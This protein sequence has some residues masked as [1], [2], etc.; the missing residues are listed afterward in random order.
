MFLDDGVYQL[1]KG[2]Q[3]KGIEMKNFSP[4]YRALEGYD[5]EKL[6]VERESLEARGLTEDDLLRDGRG[7][8]RAR[9]MGE[10]MDEQDVVLS[11]LSRREAMLHIV[12]KSPARARCARRAACASRAPGGAAADRGRRLRRHPRQRR[13]G[14]AARG[15]RAGCK[16]YV[17][18]PDLEARG[19][20]D[21]VHRRRDD[22]RLRRLR[23]PR[24]RAQELPILAVTRSAIPST[25]EENRM[26]SI[27]VNGKTYETDEEGYLVNLAD[28]NED[29]ANA[30]RARPR[31]SR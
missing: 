6:Y 20:A 1:K 3:T 17:L 18:L 10:L 11:L 26:A 28:W 16:V 22:R 25:L 14:Q 4:T 30:H 27:E 7:A 21:R 23:R 15:A 19:V 31:T 2:Q 5:V 29:V 8:R 13:R 24:G 12:N 9:E